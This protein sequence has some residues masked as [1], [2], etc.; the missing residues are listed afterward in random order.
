[1]VQLIK[2]YESTLVT[3][4]LFC[5]VLPA[6]ISYI[7]LALSSLLLFPIVEDFLI[8]LF[9]SKSAIIRAHIQTT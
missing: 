3:E 5:K 4:A 2:F 6:L 8:S 9:P 7:L 1:V